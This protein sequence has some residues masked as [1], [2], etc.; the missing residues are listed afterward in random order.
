[1]FQTKVVEQIKIHFRRKYSFLKIVPFMRYCGK[2]MAQPDRSHVA[3]WCCAGNTCFAC[4]ST[5]ARPETHTYSISYSLLHIRLIPSDLVKCFVATDTKNDKLQSTYLSLGS[6]VP[7]VCLKKT[8]NEHSSVAMLLV[9][10]CKKTDVRFILA[11]TALF[12]STQ[13]F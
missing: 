10:L 4:G 3:I 8:R 6:V 7:S 12:Y 1:M 2:N 9:S 11:T 5:V 13:Y